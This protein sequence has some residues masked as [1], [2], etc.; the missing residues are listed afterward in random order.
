ME[1]GVIEVRG[2]RIRGVRR[3]GLWSFSGIPYAA[4]P[5]G[6]RRWRP[7]APPLP[8][9]GI[10]EC[11]R[12]GPIAPQLPG[13]MEAALS[14]EPAEKSEDCLNLNI[15]TPGLDGGRRPVM[16]WIHG[17][18]FVS[19]SGSSGLYRGGTL[20][21]DGDV[22]VVTINYRLGMLGFLA[23]PALEAD[24]EAWL[25]GEGWA[26]FGNWGLADQVAALH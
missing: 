7:P 23:H 13:V 12:F 18:S 21:G 11:D 2:G 9:T 8:W 24:D 14:G 4:S 16:V 20:A 25:D 3:H 17:G 26:G 22:V 10:R 15:W 6:H 19:G 5:D 1:D